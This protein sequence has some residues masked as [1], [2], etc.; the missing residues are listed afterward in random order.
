MPRPGR[1]PSSRITGVRVTALVILWLAVVSVA[2]PS[3]GLYYEAA[4]AYYTVPILGL[5]YAYC[6][7]HRRRSTAVLAVIA[8][9]VAALAIGL[10]MVIPKA[11]AA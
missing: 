11:T 10:V 8:T 3:I 1:S 9:L 4:A 7:S 5:I 2:A 6:V